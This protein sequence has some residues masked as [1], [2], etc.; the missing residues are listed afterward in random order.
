MLSTADTLRTLLGRC[1]L[2][3]SQLARCVGCSAS[4]IS[5]LVNGKARG[6]LRMMKRLAAALVVRLAVLI[7]PI[8][9][10][11]KRRRETFGERQL[12]L[13]ITRRMRERA[14]MQ[15]DLAAALR[16]QPTTVSC[17]LGGYAPLPRAWL[18]T[19]ITFIGMTRSELLRGIR[20]AP[21]T[22]RR[23][24]RRVQVRRKPAHVERV[25]DYRLR[26]RIAAYLK[27][28]GLSQRA[29][30]REVRVHESMVSYVLTGRFRLPPAW[31]APTA[32]LLGMTPTALLA[33]IPWKPTRRQQPKGRS[34]ASHPSHRP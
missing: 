9:R 12:R 7:G 14:L 29:L 31:L 30:A 1:G 16:L 5:L 19:L 13:R 34:P 2:S 22:R 21:H 26:L 28:N 23:S 32:R 17:V 8:R 25:V 33:G 20:W 15:K 11:S 24:P 4:Y 27:R 18:P 3:Q 6:S 10:P